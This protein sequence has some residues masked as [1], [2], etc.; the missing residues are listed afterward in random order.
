MGEKTLRN[1]MIGSQIMFDNLCKDL[2][3][4]KIYPWKDPDASEMLMEYTIWPDIKVYSTFLE[5][6][7]FN[8]DLKKDIKKGKIQVPRCQPTN[9]R[10]T[11]YISIALEAE[12]VL[13]KVYVNV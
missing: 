5:K 13:K 6:I 11:T 4:M 10:L 2:P 3:F 7:N 12:R 8:E 1:S 9:M